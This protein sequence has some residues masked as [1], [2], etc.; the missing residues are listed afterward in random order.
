MF[1]SLLSFLCI[2]AVLALP[3]CAL[4][5]E[6][7]AQPGYRLV[8]TPP[9][10]ISAAAP[11]PR[12]EPNPSPFPAPAIPAGVPVVKVALLLPLSGD[13][14]ALGQAMLD[15]ATLALYDQYFTLKPEQMPVKIVLLP[16]DT[17]ASPSTTAALTQ[18]AVDEGASLIVGPVF[19]PFVIAAAPVA[20]KAR[21]PMITLSNNRAL[22][23]EGVYVFGFLPEQ[24]VAR[25]AE[26]A[27]LK[28][29]SSFAA[30]VPSDAYGKTVSDALV[31]SLGGKGIRV[32]PVERYAQTAENIE[33]AAGR[34]QEAYGRTSFSALFLGEGGSQLNPLLASLKAH[35]LGH[36]KVRYLGTGLWDD[37]ETRKLSLL[38][39]AWFASAPPEYYAAFE[40]RFLAAYGYRPQRL[41]SLAYDAVNLA[42]LLAARAHGPNFSAGALTSPQGFTGP[43]NGLFRF[44]PD[45]TTQRSLTVMEI[46]PSGLAILDPGPKMF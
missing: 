34:L 11:V 22:A 18:Q 40:R 28:K 1:K 36:D 16:K 39:G 3:A 17:G 42:F 7:P 15:A 29:I 13:S 8:T 5:P 32:S 20:R 41:S 21:I 44:K 38:Q 24:Q 2:G 45:G 33:A 4:Q 46:T 30:L 14:Q 10:G 25:V 35:G 26:Y 12:P 43:A 9:E 27:F 19:T 23:G 6:R 31:A 37:E